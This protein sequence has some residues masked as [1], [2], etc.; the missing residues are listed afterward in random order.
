MSYLLI[1]RPNPHG[2]H[3]YPSRRVP[4]SEVRLGVVHTGENLPDFDPPD[5][6]G[7]SL[8]K[9]GRTTSRAVSWHITVDSDSTIPM[10]PDDHVAWHVRGYNTIS[11]GMEQ[12][13]R[14]AQWDDAPDDW[15]QG[16]IQQAAQE[17]ARWKNELKIAITRLSL[18]QVRDG[19]RGLVGHAVLDPGRRSD[20]GATYPWTMLMDFA[21]TLAR[22]GTITQ[23]KRPPAKS[24]DGV[25]VVAPGDTL[26]AIAQA[27]DTTV[28]ILVSY[29]DIEDPD[30]I[31]VGQKIG[32]VEPRR[33][34]VHVREPV[35]RMGD[36][37]KAVFAW[38]NRLEDWWS[39]ALPEYGAD[40]DFGSETRI[41][42]RTFQKWARI[43]DDGLVG[44][45]TRRTMERAEDGWTPNIVHLDMPDYD[46][47][48]IMQPP[49]AHGHRVMLWQRALNHWIPNL[50]KVDGAFGPISDQYT[51][52][53]Q[54]LHG[55]TVDGKV[56][57]RSWSTMQGL[58]A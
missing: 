18:A 14:A 20:P 42:T 37:G 36:H 8:A 9:Y 31:Q 47:T 49:L 57:P 43:Q 2:N 34:T 12:A 46:G 30:I 41:A 7:E 45:K 25:H 17:A 29:N 53:F 52:M 50:L 16:I 24:D 40:R 39:D 55:L 26:S 23:P 48:L 58:L 19:K 10:L 22:G 3:F 44:K 32:I 21:V 11:V 1:D 38:Q 56:G 27:Y 4:M 6:S 5:S 33:P 35:L 15:V 13:T 28:K 51:R 54:E